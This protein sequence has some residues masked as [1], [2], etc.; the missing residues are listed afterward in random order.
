MSK[1]A[2]DLATAF[3]EADETVDLS[4]VIAEAW[5]ALAFFWA[6][7]L[8]VFYQFITRYVFNDSAA[9]GSNTG[10]TAP[11]VSGDAGK[12][13][14]SE[15]D[16]TLQDIE[17]TV[18]DNNAEHWNCIKVLEEWQVFWKEFSDNVSRVAATHG[19][20]R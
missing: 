13:S 16:F 7:G 1:A 8:T 10:G 19:N 4:G 6:L 11:T 12:A 5:L 14:T 3:G 2:E 17:G 9:A 15:T 18:A 20:N